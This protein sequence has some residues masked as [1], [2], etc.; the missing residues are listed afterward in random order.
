[1]NFIEAINV[2]R[3]GKGIRLPHWRAKSHI[4]KDEDVESGYVI[5]LDQRVK[6]Y[7]FKE[8]EMLSDEWEIYQEE[9]PKLHSFE[10]ALAAFKDGK[11][12]KRILWTLLSIEKKINKNLY[13]E[14]SIIFTI[15]DFEAN[16]WIIEERDQ[17]D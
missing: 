11:S 7:Q 4:K 13:S 9:A 3:D 1:M 15:D 2:M 5:C 14:F 8:T 16:D 10:E 17:N 12:I 6:Y